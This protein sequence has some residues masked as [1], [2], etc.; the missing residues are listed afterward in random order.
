MTE[1]R[2]RQAVRAAFDRAAPTYDQAAAVQREICALLAGLAADHLP[3]GPLHR[4]LDAGCGTGFGLAHLRRLCPEAACLAVDFAPAMLARLPEHPQPVCADLEALPLTAGAVDAVWSSLALQWC[5]PH[6]ALAELARVLRPGGRAWIAT[7]GPR[8]L[9]ELRAAFAQVDRAEHVIPFHALQEWTMAATAAGL[10]IAASQQ[11]DAFA[12]AP[13]LRPLLRDIK[14]IG[15]HQVGPGRRR[16]PMG[17][18]A[19]LRLEQAYEAHRGADGQLPA[20]YDV[21]LLALA[22]PENPP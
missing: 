14:A 6:R 2:H 4:V 9:W 21:I 18:S 20:T 22:K 11:Q 16:Q 13:G 3:Q 5:V 15:A 10:G 12:S 8:T 19:W 7:L 1:G 17:K